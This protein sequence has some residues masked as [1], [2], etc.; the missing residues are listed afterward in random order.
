MAD[1]A[2][3]EP[4]RSADVAVGLAATTIRAGV[5]AGRVAMA[6]ARLL[7]RSFLLQPIVRDAADGLADSGRRAEARAGRHPE[8]AAAESGAGQVWYVE[9]RRHD[10]RSARA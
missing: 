7:A 8:E 6:P 2:R 5:V 3:D 4:G 9:G 10:T 1:P